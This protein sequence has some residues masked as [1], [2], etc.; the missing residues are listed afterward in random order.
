MNKDHEPQA[1]EVDTAAP[2][3]GLSPFVKV[4]VVFVLLGGALSLL[5]FGS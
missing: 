4:V 1:I 2:R 5:M 3:A